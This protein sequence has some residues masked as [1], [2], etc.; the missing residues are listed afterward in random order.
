MGLLIAPNW[1]HEMGELIAPD[2]V[3]VGLLIA[4]DLVLQM[5][6]LNAPCPLSFPS[7]RLPAHF[8]AG[9]I[10]QHVQTYAKSDPLAQL[11]GGPQVQWCPGHQGKGC[12]WLVSCPSRAQSRRWPWMVVGR[13]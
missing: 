4:P 11:L 12:P 7:G 1:M 6:L 10:L 2:L 3:R 8:V 5:G 13:E 9:T